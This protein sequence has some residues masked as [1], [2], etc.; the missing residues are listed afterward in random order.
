MQQI[1]DQRSAYSLLRSPGWKLHSLRYLLLLLS[2][3]AFA[4][5]DASGAVFVN[6][7]NYVLDS[8][9]V[10]GTVDIVASMTL[11]QSQVATLTGLVQQQQQQI[12]SH[13]AEIAQLRNTTSSISSNLTE[14]IRRAK[15]AEGTLTNSISSE[16][17][18]ALGVESALTQQI[19]TMQAVDAAQNVSILTL[20]LTAGAHTSTIIALQTR[21]ATLSNQLSAVQSNL[22]VVQS[23]AATLQ[24]QVGSLQGVDAVQNLTISVLQSASAT[25]AAQISTLQT[26]FGDIQAL[27]SVQNSNISV[28]QSSSA[29]Q[30]TSISMLQAAS[31]T[32]A[33]QVSSLQIQVGSLQGVDAVQN[34]TISVLQSASATQSSQVSTLQ[35][36]LGGIQALDSVQNSN[37]SV[38]QSSSAA[39]STSISMLQAASATQASQVSSL[40]IQVG[41]LQ[42]VDAVQN[43]TISV[44]QSASATQ[45]AQISTL[46][47]QFGDIQALDSVQNS[48]ISVLQSSSAAQSTSIS[49]LQAASATQASQVSSLQIQVGSLQ[50]VDAVQNLTISVLQLASATQ[51]SQIGTLQTQLGGIQGVDTSQNRSISVLQSAVA[52]MVSQSTLRATTALNLFLNGAFDVWQRLV[53]IAP[54]PTPAA[55]TTSYAFSGTD[56]WLLKCAGTWTTGCPV[57]QQSTANPQNAL[58]PYSL[59]L[60]GTPANGA[61][62]LA[63]AQRVESIYAK[64]LLAAGY[65]SVSVQVQSTVQQ[66]I[67]EFY[68]ADSADVFTSVTLFNTTTLTLASSPSSFTLVKLEGVAVPAAAAARGIEVRFRF[69]NYATLGIAQDLTVT[70]FVLT[71]DQLVGN[72]R[73]VGDSVEGEVAACQRYYYQTANNILSTGYF[74]NNNAYLPLYFPVRMRVTPA[75]RVLGT[76]LANVAQ[77]TN[78]PTSPLQVN[79][80]GIA[81]W[82]V[83]GIG[84]SKAGN[85]TALQVQPTSAFIADAEL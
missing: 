49:M 8:P 71:A 64:S 62:E 2:L 79:Q 55:L 51:S 43:L 14:E 68:T 63:I 17:N 67:V 77:V 59:L 11:L 10:V 33:S 38:L 29:A 41:S 32:Q 53:T 44:L 28:L 36:Q 61:S 19:S 4:P 52:T 20:D 47:T 54:A 60:S 35:T 18:R 56:R 13:E 66:L 21:N 82:S 58:A 27:D 76:I 84:T 40:Q 48:N 69:G 15:T 39:Q 85:P 30:S 9:L 45:A 16:M 72:F 70:Q 23:I 1:E 24:I 42:G 22:G 73:R 26:Q 5:R 3:L 50:G 12:T 80:Q 81:V 57:P 25:Q 75:V 74:D 65:L 6:P 46:Q 31:A 37:I 83:P 34:L 7:T 78:L